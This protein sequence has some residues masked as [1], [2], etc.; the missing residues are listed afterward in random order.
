MTQPEIKALEKIAELEAELEKFNKR[1]AANTLSS[2]QRSELI[3]K[4]KQKKEEL[5]L[6]YYMLGMFHGQNNNYFNAQQY[7]ER[8]VQMKPDFLNAWN[9][10]GNIYSSNKEYE[11]AINAYQEA[12]KIRPNS[13]SF[14]TLA[15][16]YGLLNDLELANSYIQKVEDELM[17]SGMDDSKQY[18]RDGVSELSVIY[19]KSLIKSPTENNNEFGKE[20]FDYAVKQLK[21]NNFQSIHSLKMQIPT[22]A[23]FVCLIGKNGDG[24]T[25]ILQALAIGLQGAEGALHLLDNYGTQI[26]VE[27]LQ[28]KKNRI[29]NL[30]REEKSWV[31]ISKCSHTA[32]YGV[33]RL[34][35]LS[36]FDIERMLKSNPFYCL[37][38]T[39]DK[40]LENIEAWFIKDYWKN[41]S[42]TPL[43]DTT[44][45]ILEKILSGLGHEIRIIEEEGTFYYIEQGFKASYGQLSAGSKSILSLLG[46]ILVRLIGQS[47]EIND[48]FDL[49]GIVLI[50][51]IESHL[52]PIAQRNLMVVLSETF[53]KVQF[54]VTTHSAI[55]LL[56][57]PENSAFYK[58]KRTQEEGTTVERLRIDVKNL[59]PNQILTS[60]LFDMEVITSASNTNMHDIHLEDTYPEIL[61]REEVRK[62]IAKILSEKYKK[63]D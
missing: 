30:Y 51:E 37:L 32:G 18:I 47:S 34:S 58:V 62:D 36:D 13:E 28:E 6:T 2:Y 24:K 50:D 54:I 21:I 5:V 3:K 27:F 59:L 41:K 10:L 43:A 60:T 12:I 17:K 20:N 63:Q 9:K 11:K 45:R 23:Q 55:C 57:M 46:D 14:Y 52:H 4:I 22:D 48:L 40:Q 42:V 56:G 61:K 31:E 7:L 53:P 33:K 25:S 39:D 16:V 26:G 8:A 38:N 29:N 35:K 15:I 49:K 44:K 1:L 19:Q